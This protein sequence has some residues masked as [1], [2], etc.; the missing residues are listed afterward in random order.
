VAT[1]DYLALAKSITD[2]AATSWEA[3]RDA[4]D[5]AA[6]RAIAADTDATALNLNTNAVVALSPS[7][8]Y[9]LFSANSDGP[10]ELGATLARAMNTADRYLATLG[11]PPGAVATGPPAITPVSNPYYEA[12]A[13][14]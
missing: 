4:P 1:F 6:F 2:V 7:L 11:Q 10:G 14:L 13:L 5:A 8:A 9:H 3:M 12:C